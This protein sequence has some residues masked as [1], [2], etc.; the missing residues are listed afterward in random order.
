MPSIDNPARARKQKGSPHHERY[1]QRL[2]AHLAAAV[3]AAEALATPTLPEASDPTP[4][5]LANRYGAPSEPGKA[6]NGDD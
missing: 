1:P 4:E 6:E 3:D 5:G 2:Q